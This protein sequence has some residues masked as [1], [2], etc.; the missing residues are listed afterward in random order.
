[1]PAISGFGRM[2]CK[3]NIVGRGDGK[4]TFDDE[5][6]SELM[7]KKIPLNKSMTANRKAQQQCFRMLTSSVT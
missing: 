6:D 2:T 4:P 1:M 5:E 7:T 3:K